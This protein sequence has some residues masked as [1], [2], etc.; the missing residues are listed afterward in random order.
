MKNSLLI[1]GTKYK[2]RLR[3]MKCQIN[4]HQTR[5]NKR[6]KN[7]GHWGMLLTTCIVWMRW[8]YSDFI[9]DYL[10]YTGA[11]YW[12]QNHIPPP[13]PRRLYFF[14][15][16]NTPL[17]PIL[18]LILP[19]LHLLYPFNFK[20]PLILCVYPFSSQFLFFLFTL[21][22]FFPKWLWLIFP[23]GGGDIFLYKDPWPYE[24]AWVL[25]KY[26]ATSGTG[27]TSLY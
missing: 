26:S 7:S 19:L 17:A 9:Y 14:P 12:S 5:N 1:L 27:C 18:S 11:I 10:P 8:L 20:F 23:P 24:N 3:M 22:I 2:V 15:F 21:F 6:K 16:L 25:Y 13:S 4:N